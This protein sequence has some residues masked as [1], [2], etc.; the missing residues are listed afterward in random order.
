[1][2]N[3]AD[4][5]SAPDTASTRCP[6]LSCARVDPCPSDARTRSGAR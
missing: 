3:D 4:R 5:D 1:V 2:S 6:I